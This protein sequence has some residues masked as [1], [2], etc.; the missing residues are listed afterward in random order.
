MDTVVPARRARSRRRRR[1]VV[2][3]QPAGGRARRGTVEVSLAA[4]SAAWTAKRVIVRCFA[5]RLEYLAVVE[6]RGTLTTARLL[7][8]KAVLATGACG[9]FTSSIGFSTVFVPT[10]TEPVQVVRP[11]STQRRSA[12]SATPP[13]VASTGSSRR[14]HCASRSVASSRCGRQMC[15][16]VPCCPSASSLRSAICASPNCATPPRWRVRTRTRL[17]RAHDDRRALRDTDSRASSR[18]RAMAGTRHSSRRSDN[19]VI[20]AR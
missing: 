11:A 1:R 20:R 6:G 3:R 2:R 5:D 15:R 8:G 18:R 10:P 17:R 13:P 4:R 19:T 12:S 16:P 14:L 9:S 7:G